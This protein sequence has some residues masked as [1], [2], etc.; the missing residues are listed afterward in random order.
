MQRE[1]WRYELES[2]DIIT[3]NFKDT[4]DHFTDLDRLNAEE[5]VKRDDPSCDLPQLLDDES[6]LPIYPTMYC[7][8]DSTCL[9]P[10]SE[11]FTREVEKRFGNGNSDEED[12]Q[13]PFC[14]EFVGSEDSDDEVIRFLQK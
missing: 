5:L 11:D 3:S 7:E 10:C 9:A 4:S 13:E 14:D 2:L 6:P 8:S 1:E 12:G